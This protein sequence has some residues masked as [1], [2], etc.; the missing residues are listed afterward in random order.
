MNNEHRSEGSTNWSERI[1]VAGTYDN[2]CRKTTDEKEYAGSAATVVT[3]RVPPKK[4]TVDIAMFHVKVH[5]QR[6]SSSS[7]D[8]SSIVWPYK[9]IPSL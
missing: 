9:N 1:I 5:E 6:S 8:S 4:S 3:A 7:S 2:V